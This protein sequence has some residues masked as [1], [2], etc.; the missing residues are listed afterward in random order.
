MESFI[1]DFLRFCQVLIIHAMVMVGSYMKK[2]TENMKK[3]TETQ[4]DIRDLKTYVLAICKEMK[5]T[6]TLKDG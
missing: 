6:C 3:Q 4:R 1:T 2:Q 5:L